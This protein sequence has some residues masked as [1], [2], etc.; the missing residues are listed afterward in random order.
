MTKENEDHTEANLRLCFDFVSQA[1][2]I[3]N[4][5][6][7]NNVGLMVIAIGAIGWLLFTDVQL[8]VGLKILLGLALVIIIGILVYTN[9]VISRSD[10]D[11]FGLQAGIIR[12]NI[13]TPDEFV[14]AYNTTVPRTRRTLNKYVSEALAQ[15][16]GSEKGK[17]A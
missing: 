9:L 11:F 2:D 8:L 13:S 3:D 4:R 12:G 15:L 1:R 10:R 5:T 7:H 6:S 17:K 16:D 14:E